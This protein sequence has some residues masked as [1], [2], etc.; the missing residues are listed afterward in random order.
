MAISRGLNIIRD[1]LKYYIDSFNT[2]TMVQGSNLYSNIYNNGFIKSELT[3]DVTSPSGSNVYKI[4][5][6]DNRSGYPNIRTILDNFVDQYLITGWI[7]VGNSNLTIKFDRSDVLLKNLTLTLNSEWQQIYIISPIQMNYSPNTWG[8]FID[9]EFVGE[10]TSG[11]YFYVSDFKI[12]KFNT[13]VNLVNKTIISTLTNGTKTID[14]NFQFDGVDD[15]ITIP[16]DIVPVSEIRTNGVS[17]AA[18]IKPSNIT[19][20]QRI[21]GQQIGSGYSDYSSGGLCIDNQR[22]KMVAYNDAGAYVY[23]NS[24]TI[25]EVNKW[26]YIVGTFDTNDKFLRLY[27]NGVL[28][29]ISTAVTIFSRLLTNSSNRIGSKDGTTTLPFNGLISNVKIYNK[30]LSIN[31]IL[32]NYNA[33]KTRFGL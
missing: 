29:G 20:N 23:T 32:I 1:G 9:I 33:F 18:W 5:S 16:S 8:R 15:Y 4:T 26:Y 25:L 10:N 7:K 3:T 12:C 11:Q 27:V 30:T 13:C 6:L 21:V 24:N 19:N 22:A 28:D 17:Y 31:E 14:T 2:K